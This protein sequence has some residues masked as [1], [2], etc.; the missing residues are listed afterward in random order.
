MQ[1]GT[2]TQIL[3]HNYMKII[4]S[5]KLLKLGAEENTET[6]TYRYQTL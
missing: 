2:L 5:V 6:K 4:V 1:N 3:T